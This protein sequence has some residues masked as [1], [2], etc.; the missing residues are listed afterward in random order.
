MWRN[1]FVTTNPNGGAFDVET[2]GNTGGY[3]LTGF[4]RPTGSVVQ[5]Q[6][7]LQRVSMSGTPVK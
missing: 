6:V 3:V 7:L 1:S 5:N 4:T 2:L